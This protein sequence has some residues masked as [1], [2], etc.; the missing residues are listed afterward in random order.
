MSGN[1]LPLFPLNAVLFPHVPMPLH[2]FE[3]RYKVLVSR[4]LEEG[5]PFG[6]IAIREGEEVGGAEV[7]T[8]TVGTVARIRAVNRLADGKFNVLVMGEERF[9]LI[10]SL[11]GA[12]P[13][14]VGIVERLPD[15]PY[16]REA[17][18]AAMQSVRLHMK[19]FL[20][21]VAERTSSEPPELEL[22]DDP[23][24]LSFQLAGLLHGDVSLCQE[25]LE[26]TD[27]ARRLSKV[28][29]M[30]AHAREN[31]NRSDVQ[32]RVVRIAPVQPGEWRNVST[33]N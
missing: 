32:I 2:I 17:L 31:L 13:Y 21:A 15:E 20:H 19:E 27:V 28:D 25:V 18:E 22:S 11:V 9:R 6:V 14:L 3:E 26:T 7:L 33:N 1:T 10:D 30:L 4:C 8:H 24:R 29:G 16:D 12:E 23:A 5:S